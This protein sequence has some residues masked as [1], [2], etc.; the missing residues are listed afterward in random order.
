MRLVRNHRGRVAIAFTT[1]ALGLVGAAAVLRD[2]QVNEIT[3]ALAAADAGLLLW[4]LVAAQLANAAKALRWGAIV[5]PGSGGLRTWTALVYL[6]QAINNFAPARAGDLARVEVQARRGGLDRA[7]LF[8]CL[9]AEKLIDLALLGVLF[10]CL[11]P[12][13]PRLT[14]LG[15][16]RIGGGAGL[17]VALLVVLALAVPLLR[18]PLTGRR[19][20][21]ASLAGR[22]A[23][24]AGVL[25]RRAA[26]PAAAWGLASWV[27]GALAN[28]WTL[29]ALGVEHAWLASFVLLLLL[30]AGAPVPALPGRV[31]FHQALCVAALA[32]FGLPSGL[33]LAVAAIVYATTIAVPS[34]VGGLVA[35]WLAR[36]SLAAPSAAGAAA[37][38]T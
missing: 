22:F 24:G 3:R 9:A 14:G 37:R 6:G 26:V 13:A 34:V 7:R 33:A 31:G 18:R 23:E 5:G 1:S 21:I 25:R 2:A 15:T 17:A 38:S 27:M 8:G 12:L 28:Y 32:P 36:S 19:G 30:Y 11:V 29:R 35:V 20:L 16:G 10:L 4:A